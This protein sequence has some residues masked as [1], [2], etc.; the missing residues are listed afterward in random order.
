MQTE[1]YGYEWNMICLPACLPAQPHGD[2]QVTY[3]KKERDCDFVRVKFDLV[4]VVPMF[5]FFFLSPSKHIMNEKWSL[6]LISSNNLILYL[7]FHVISF[8]IF[9]YEF[10][11]SNIWFFFVCFQS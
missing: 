9:E 6:I 4:D 11:V 10:K 5:P 2:V 3:R 1:R 7:L 8:I